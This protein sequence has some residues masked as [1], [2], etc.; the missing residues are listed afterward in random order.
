MALY[1]SSRSREGGHQNKKLCMHSAQ[2]PPRCAG[3]AA[4]QDTRDGGVVGAA[5]F[6]KHRPDDVGLQRRHGALACALRGYRA[7]AAA[8]RKDRE[9]GHDRRHEAV[10][11]HRNGAQLSLV[12]NLPRKQSLRRFEIS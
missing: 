7:R 10:E 9:D 6:A 12:D 3:L 1:T 4:G 8:R 5:A 2:P 11:H